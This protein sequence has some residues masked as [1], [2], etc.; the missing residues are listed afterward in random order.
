MNKKLLLLSL[1]ACS[2]I[3][4]LEGTYKDKTKKVKVKKEKK[5]KKD[6]GE[7]AKKHREGKRGAACG[8]S[9]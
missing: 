3:V 9:K 5:T 7:Q 2:G 8:C 4:H 6:S 1:L